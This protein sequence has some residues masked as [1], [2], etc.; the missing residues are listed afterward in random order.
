M[1][2]LFSS[3]FEHAAVGAPATL[4]LPPLVDWPEDLRSLVAQ[5]H[6]IVAGGCE[7]DGR[8]ISP[9]DEARLRDIGQ[10][11]VGQVD[12]IALSAVF[13]P[14][15][16]E[17]ERRAAAILREAVGERIPISLSHETLMPTDC[18]TR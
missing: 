1:L 13:A 6:Y 10:A 12:A 15:N 5:A 14:V 16:P 9:L 7:F 2:Q 11:L 4:A 8:E 18:A 3:I 17:H